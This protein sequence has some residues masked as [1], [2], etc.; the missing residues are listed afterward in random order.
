MIAVSQADIE[1]N[2][3][4]YFASRFQRPLSDFNELT[5]LKTAFS[6][7]DSAWAA[8]ADTFSSLNWMKTI[9]VTL[10][11]FEMAGVQ[12]VGDLTALIWKHVPKMIAPRGTS[13]SITTLKAVLV[14]GKP[15]KKTRKKP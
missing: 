11:P 14:S 12:T 2:V 1:D 10:A 7:N 5:N 3:I 4:A 9:G 15:R 6:F 8:L 13:K